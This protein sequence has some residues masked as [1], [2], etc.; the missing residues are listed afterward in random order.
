MC[1]RT[2]LGCEQVLCCHPTGRVEMDTVS[3]AAMRDRGYW[4]IHRPR[5]VPSR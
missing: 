2:R 1:I 3:T 4:S 5:P